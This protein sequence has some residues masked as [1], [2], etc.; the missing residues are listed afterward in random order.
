VIVHCDCEGR[1]GFKKRDAGRRCDALVAA[2]NH[3]KQPRHLLEDLWKDGQVVEV[4]EDTLQSR[5]ARQPRGQLTEAVA[6]EGEAFK[7]F[8]AAHGVGQLAEAVI[9]EV[10]MA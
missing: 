2:Q 9:A 7:R 3:F 8:E 4:C 1:R 6:R 10:Q 5:Q